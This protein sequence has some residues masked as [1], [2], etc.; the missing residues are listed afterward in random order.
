MAKVY[1]ARD[2][3][4]HKLWAIKEVPRIARSRL[5]QVAQRSLYQEALLMKQFDHP[6][7]PRIVDIRKT[8]GQ[9]FIIMDYIR[10]KDLRQLLL[11]QGAWDEIN[12]RKMGIQL[13]EVLGYLHH[14]N[15]PVL[16]RDLKPS[17]IILSPEGRIKLIDFGSAIEMTEGTE[18]TEKNSSLGTPG[19][20]SPEQIRGEM[21][22]HRS[23]I[24]SLG[25]T[26]Y[27]LLTGSLNPAAQA[28]DKA[29]L[30]H[31]SPG[32]RQIIE[33]CTHPC[34]EK[35]YPNTAALLSDLHKFS[36]L[37]QHP[38]S[39]SR[40][41][42]F[43]KPSD[44]PS[45]TQFI[46]FRK[47]MLAFCLIVSITIFLFHHFYQVGQS[48]TRYKQLL[49][50]HASQTSEE[51]RANCIEAIRL[52][53][54]QRE[55]YEKLLDLYAADGFFTKEESEELLYLYAH[56]MEAAYPS[57][58]KQAELEERIGE[59]YLN[60]YQEEG[61]N[62]HPNEEHLQDDPL[63]ELPGDNFK[64]RLRRAAPFLRSD[65]PKRF[66]EQTQE[67]SL[68]PDESPER[69][70]PASFS[71]YF[72]ILYQFYND[73]IF[74]SSWI[75]ADKESYRQLLERMEKAEGAMHDLLESEQ[76]TLYHTFFL[77]LY[78]QRS[79]LA[80]SGI[81]EETVLNHMERMEAQTKKLAV[82]KK[83]L[84]TLQNE[85]LENYKSYREAVRRTYAAQKE[86]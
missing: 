82:R 25:M 32:M 20:A 73:Y 5:E 76:L 72:S 58:E 84:K 85:I 27:A 46:F 22:D 59:L 13:A 1:L 6:A 9:I 8:R 43:K 62:H 56:Q 7:I 28:A 2:G 53:P 86:K 61:P 77:F 12:V 3:P 80:A 71:D 49:Y 21:P 35:R 33:K 11:E 34:P 65:P 74:G 41:F 39:Y 60:Y 19:Y 55:A 36:D 51:K 69:Q 16:Y 26:L 31:F 68:K 63:E 66:S 37:V 50:A 40:I 24:Y 44:I 54:K 15:P 70:R 83:T 64:D 75:E 10:G 4:L 81:P 57:E 78:D 45:R 29:K 14:R 52:F 38:S 42:P 47:K 67:K 30:V 23:D 79:E 18:N 17:N 48:R